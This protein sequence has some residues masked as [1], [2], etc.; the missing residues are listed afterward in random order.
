MQQKMPRNIMNF[1]MRTKWNE[2][3]PEGRAAW[4]AEIKH[5][6]I[7]HSKELITDCIM[8]WDCNKAAPDKVAPGD[9]GMTEEVS[10]IIDTR[11]HFLCKLPNHT[12]F[13]RPDYSSYI[14]DMSML[15]CLNLPQQQ[16]NLPRSF[17]E[18]KEKEIKPEALQKVRENIVTRHNMCCSGSRRDQELKGAKRLIMR[19]YVQRLLQHAMRERPI[20]H[21]AVTSKSEIE[22]LPP[23]MEVV[24]YAIGIHCGGIILNK[25]GT[26]VTR[27]LFKLA[28]TVVL[29]EIYQRLRKFDHY[30]WAQGAQ[31]QDIPTMDD[32]EHYQFINLFFRQGLYWDLPIQ[33]WPIIH[34]QR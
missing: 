5:G 23:I 24:V 21:T 27:K 4:Q 6:D 31:N 33:P 25:F 17:L 15:D 30:R 8:E 10:E 26:I 20:S 9:I 34:S 2:I 14:Y 32:E 19:S 22:L 16:K 28:A 11:Y 1:E 7:F 29:R 12:P 13:Q 3:E 18:C